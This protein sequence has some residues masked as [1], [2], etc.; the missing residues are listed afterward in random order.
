[1]LDRSDL[2]RLEAAALRDGMI[3]RWA[4]AMRAVEMG[5]TSPAEVRRVLGFDDT[6]PAEV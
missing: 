5:V 3:S 2:D 1:V 4:R 6:R